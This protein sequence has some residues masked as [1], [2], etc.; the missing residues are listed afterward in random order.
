MTF[1]LER[2]VAAR[3]GSKAIRIAAVIHPSRGAWRFVDRT[4]RHFALIW[5]NSMSLRDRC[6]FAD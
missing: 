1:L 2:L 4:W 6:Q 5:L 3:R